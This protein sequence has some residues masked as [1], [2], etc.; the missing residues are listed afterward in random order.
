MTEVLDGFT[1]V[2]SDGTVSLIRDGYVDELHSALLDPDQLEPLSNAGRGTIRQCR[3]GGKQAVIREYRR[4]GFVRHFLK[5]HYL[6][7]NRPW[8]ELQVWDYAHREGLS[9]PRPLGAV[10]KRTGPF[11]SGAIASELI[12]AQHLEDWMKSDLDANIRDN[13]LFRVGEQFRRMHDL[14]IWH[15]D[16]QVR[17]VLIDRQNQ[18]YLIDFDNARMLDTVDDAKTEE[19]LKRFRRSFLKRQVPLSRIVPIM[20]GYGLDRREAE[21]WVRA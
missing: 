10:W 2:E 6:L 9:V 18:T 16:L 8:R 20:L 15:A 7:D 14:G 1:R 4:G 21:R 13:V 5:K 17:N 11:Y 19:N 12:P 3:A